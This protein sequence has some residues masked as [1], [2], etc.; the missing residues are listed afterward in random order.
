[1][2]LIHYSCCCSW[3]K[4]TTLSVQCVC[5]WRL[6]SAGETC[7]TVNCPSWVI[8]LRQKYLRL[9][10]LQSCWDAAQVRSTFF[11][12]SGTCDGEVLLHAQLIL[13][14]S[15]LFWRNFLH[16][17]ASFSTQLW[18]KLPVSRLG[19]LL[20]MLALFV[21]L[22]L[23]S[24]NLLCR[25]ALTPEM[26]EVIVFCPRTAKS[27]HFDF[28]TAKN[29]THTSSRGTMATPYTVGWIVVFFGCSSV[30][31]QDSEQIPQYFHM[32]Q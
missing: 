20:N 6:I 31:I 27:S 19:R 1:M 13:A 9:E 15:D 14:N 4:K 3:W 18:Q 25:T 8:F 29:R 17:R 30:L 7:F 5:V 28:S 23:T 2:L 24:L 26:K 16:C 10:P 32:L 11:F 12:L 22:L 21:R